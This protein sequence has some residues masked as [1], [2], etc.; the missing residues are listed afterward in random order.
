MAQDLSPS[1]VVAEVASWKRG[2]DL[3]RLVHTVAFAA[4]D[5]QRVTLTDGLAEAIDRAGIT[6]EEAETPFGNVLHILAE[7]ASPDAPG[8]A[9]LSGLLARGVALFLPEG[10]EAE[11]HVAESLLWLAT[12]TP[13]DGF[14]SLDAALGTATDGLW[15]A[16]GNLVRA[17]DEAPSARFGRA[18]CIVGA[19]AL[20]GS[21]SDFAQSEADDLAA[22]VH[23]PIVRRVLTDVRP[24]GAAGA[25]AGDALSG[26]LTAP[27]R[28]T[29]VMV[30]LGV[31]GILFAIELAR[32]VARFALQYRAPAEL[33][34]SRQGVTVRTRTELLGRILREREVT[35]P[36]AAL[37]KAS[38]ETRY[39]RVLLYAGLFSLAV[40]S[41]L[42]IGLCI[43]GARAGSPELLGI[44]AL[45]VAAGLALDF[46]LENARSGLTGKCRL[47]LCPRRGAA[48]AIAN[49][50]P[51][52]ADVAL[53]R[54][55]H[56]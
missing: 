35:I 48:L 40:G 8:K 55:V 1:A 28:S 34:V 16:V 37:A 4:A 12:R 42:G 27:P 23:D 5:E 45:L 56:G 44:G 52:A 51:A 46:V 9:V 30:A 2:D 49:I 11:A 29:L 10:S 53:R 20:R 21:S 7:P 43:D 19:A 26:E 14:A 18:A 47:V 38:R 41:Y 25:E 13:V 15:S 31:T 6:A 22:V 33:R 24:G 3:A 50:D 36:I 39:P 17:L 32:L 54:L